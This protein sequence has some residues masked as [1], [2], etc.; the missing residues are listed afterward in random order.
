LVLREFALGLGNAWRLQFHGF[1]YNA[2]MKTNPISIQFLLVLALIAACVLRPAAAEEC[3][4]AS[5]H[6]LA[7]KAGCEILRSGGNAFDAAVAVAAALAVVEPFA[8]G[9]GG[10]G[11]FLLH[12]ASDNFEV[13]VDA[14]ETAPTRATREFFVDEDGQAKQKASLEGPTAAGIPGEPAALDWVAGRYGKLPLARALAPAIQLAERGF[15]ADPR[16]ATASALRE[17]LLKNNTHAATSFLDSGKAVAPGFV[18]IQP[19]LA[20]TLRMLADQ[21]R[22]SFYHGDFAR[23]LVQTVKS[24]GGLWELSDLENYRVIERAPIKFTYRGA[25]ITTAPLPSS[26]GLVLAQSLFILES[27]NLAGLCATDRAH[28]AVEAMRRGYHDR[29]RYMGDSDFFVVPVVKL[30]SREYAQRRGASIDPAR[31]TPSSDLAQEAGAAGEGRDTTHFSIIDADGN[32][33]AATLSVNGP[34]GSGFVAGDTGVLLNNHMDDFV[35]VPGVP[36]LYKLVGS[37]ANAIEPGKRPL[38]SMSPT[39]VEDDRGV[40]VLGTPGGSRII[41]M[42]LE[43]ILD[44]VDQPQTDLASLVAAPRFHHQY[45]PDR[46]EIEPDGFPDQ[47]VE[48]MKAKGHAV[49]LGRRKWGNMQAV[50]FDKKTGRI[51]TASDPRGQNGVLF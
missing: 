41:S 31:A 10:G 20:H 33:V 45:L 47:W 15:P 46:I 21:G 34:F 4:I 2:S 25:K 1:S 13:F 26:G 49:E 7:T 11:F 14:R 35:L 36:N 16:Y 27:V 19:Q 22:Q 23:R 29:A 38:S 30:A 48:A 12:R 39:F 42:V 32:R 3:G 51:E 9:I 28:Y 50:F 6:A 40:L 17:A 24:A 43:G 44:Y 8:S 5:A 37:R 18:V